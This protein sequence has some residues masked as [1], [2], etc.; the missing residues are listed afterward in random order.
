MAQWTEEETEPEPDSTCLQ[1]EAYTNYRNWCGTQ[2]LRGMCKK[3]FTDKLKERGFET[4]Q[5][6]TGSRARVYRGFRLTSGFSQL[7][8]EQDLFQ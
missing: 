6:S 4:G 3:Q 1:V 5:Q 2:G 8:S 7:P